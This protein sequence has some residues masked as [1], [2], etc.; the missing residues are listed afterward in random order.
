MGISTIREL[1]TE[2]G[3]L[4]SSREEV[5]GCIFGRDSLIT[6]LA[7]L[8][9][10]KRIGDPFFLHLVKK[11]LL[12]LAK[13]QGRVKN[14]ES[15]EQP[16]KCIHE[17]RRQGHEHLTKKEIRPW[18]LYQDNVMRNYDSVDSTP[19][20]LIA[21]YRYYQAS[22]DEE[23]LRATRHNI[24]AAL[25]WIILYADSNQDGFVDYQFPPERQSGGLVTQSWMDSTESVFHEDGSWITYPIAPMEVQAYTFLALRLWSNHYQKS[26]PILAERL[27]RRASE[28]KKIFNQKFLSDSEIVCAIDGAGKPLRSTRSSIG[29]TLWAALTGEDMGKYPECILR[30]EFISKVVRRLLEPDMFE[31]NGGIR[32]LSSQS[33]KF[34]PFGYHMGSIWPHDNGMIAQGFENFGFYQEAN[35][36][37]R[38]ITRAIEHFGSPVELFAFNG[39]AVQRYKSACKKQ[40][41]SAAT[42]LVIASLAE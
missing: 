7:L 18:Y 25:N 10:H 16:G 1:E 17:F 38:A 40:A 19:L 22:K 35:L 12:N 42:L 33:V 5:F 37:H 13:L 32:T 39:D 26:D 34:D 28:L 2:E 3:I 30:E 20:M 6:D 21:F 14:I 11:S 41:W 24:E 4:A 31:P 36:I 9:V 23:F 15:G 8:K 29:H 27:G